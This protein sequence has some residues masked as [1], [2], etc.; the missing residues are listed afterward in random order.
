MPTYA[1]TVSRVFSEYYTYTITAESEQEA[2]DEAE[3]RA[4]EET[5]LPEEA[6]QEINTI[7]ITEIKK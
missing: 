7:N 5:L 6:D 3:N 1:I 4:D 2:I